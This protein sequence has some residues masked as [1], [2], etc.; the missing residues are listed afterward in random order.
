[1]NFMED[2]LLTGEDLEKL[3]FVD[4]YYETECYEIQFI[5]YDGWNL[6]ITNKEKCGPD[7][8]Y[9]GGFC[10]GRLFNIIYAVTGVDFLGESNNELLQEIFNDYEHEYYEIDPPPGRKEYIQRIMDRMMET[11]PFL[12][13][14]GNEEK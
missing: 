9:V 14:E 4:G 8:V 13:R 11:F 12:K 10:I 5:F 3:G 1:M 2:R 6:S 7:D